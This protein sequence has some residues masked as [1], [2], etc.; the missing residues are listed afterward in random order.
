MQPALVCPR[1]QWRAAPGELRRK[2]LPGS[3]TR[4][5]GDAV[6]GIVGRLPAQHAGPE[7]REAERVVRAGAERVEA[8]EPSATAALLVPPFTGS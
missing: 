6:V 4:Q 5:E 7:V 8:R 1:H 2:L 3:M